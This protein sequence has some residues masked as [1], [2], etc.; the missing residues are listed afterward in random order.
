MIVGSKL[1]N[2]F[3][4][5]NITDDIPENVLKDIFYKLMTSDKNIISQNISSHKRNLELLCK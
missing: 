1:I 3:I 4:N 5:D 2:S